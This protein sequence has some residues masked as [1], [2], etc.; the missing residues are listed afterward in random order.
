MSRRFT[1]LSYGI[2][3]AFV[4]LCGAA[5]LVAQSNP[6]AA[7]VCEDLRDSTPGLYGLCVAFNQGHDCEADFNLPEPFVDCKP[8]S[9]RIYD[10]YEDKRQ[11]DDPDMP[12]VVP[13]AC[14]CFDE[15]HLDNIPGSVTQCAVG[16]PHSKGTA[17]NAIST[18]DFVYQ[19]ID[20]DTGPG[21]ECIRLEPPAP[22][23]AASLNDEQVDACETLIADFCVE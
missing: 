10:L 17:S 11:P 4:L 16:E 7:G 1:I 18:L 20:Y 6:P 12:G 22:V 14:L 2:V 8:A 19:V 21:G 9:A 3:S 15:T 23:F 5:L 13:G